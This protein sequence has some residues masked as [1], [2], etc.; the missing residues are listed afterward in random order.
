MKYSILIN[1]KLAIDNNLNIDIIDLAIFEYI[2]DFCHSREIQKMM[3]NEKV[4][5]WISYQKII[6]DMP[7]LGIK[8][9]DSVY[10]RLKKLVSLWIIEEN[11]NNAKLWRSYFCFWENYDTL[12]FKT[13]PLGFKTEPSDQKPYPPGSK[14]V[15]PPDGKSDDNII[16]DNIININ[17]LSNDNIEQALVVSEENKEYWNKDINDILQKLKVSIWLSDFKEDSKWQRRYAKNILSLKNKIWEQEFWIRLKETLEDWFKAK[18]CNKIAYV[19]GELKS[20]IHSPI[21]EEKDD[22]NKIRTF[23]I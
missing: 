21:V 13:D 16:N 11:K 18:N 10:R 8:T 6:D 7:I 4:Y 23:V 22:R 15:P 17:I 19:Y 2:K 14:T 12:V 5:Y 3:E 9:K 1:Q 20:F